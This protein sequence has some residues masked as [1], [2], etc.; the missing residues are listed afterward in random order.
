MSPTALPSLLA[1]A[2][3]DHLLYATDWPYAADPIVGAFTGMYE[4]YSLD[5]SAR[6]SIDRGNAEKLFPRLRG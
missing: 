1:L 4:R 6:A 5:D 3:P 2:Q